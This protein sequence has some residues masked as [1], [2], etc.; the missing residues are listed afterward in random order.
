[1]RMIK[2][3]Y[4]DESLD[5]S[6]AGAKVK[7]LINEH[8]IELGINPKIPPIE[9]LSDDFIANLK[10]HSQGDPEA[11]ASEMEHAIR[12]H[13][14]VHFDEDPAFYKRLSEKLEKLIENYKNNWELLTEGYE[15]LRKEAVEGRKET[16]EG[17]SKEATTFYD[18]VVQLAFDGQKMPDE[19]QEPL[20]NLMG[21]IV[22]ILQDTIG[23]L[24][25]WKKPIEVKKL[26]G[27][28]DTE[29]LLVEI[30]QLS[31]KHERI[32]VEIIKLAEKRNN[33]LIK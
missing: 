22:E 14:T 27:N 15:E 13:C 24:D 2:E 32:A 10:K 11:K 6:D 21:R 20:K 28:I 23:I 8:L 4:K 26:R 19:Y 1:L 9:L 18:Y 30:P 29:I 17:L 33:E 5:I 25:F 16:V 31:E 12:K 3:R 7:A